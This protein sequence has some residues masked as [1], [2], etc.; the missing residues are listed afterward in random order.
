RGSAPAF[1]ARCGCATVATRCRRFGSS[2]YVATLRRAALMLC[3]SRIPLHL[4]PRLRRL[5][6]RAPHRGLLLPLQHPHRV[7]ARFAHQLVVVAQAVAAD[8]LAH[9][10][11]RFLLMA[12]VAEAALPRE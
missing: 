1:D 7:A 2:G 12:A 9:G 5:A 3:S 10:A 8:A 4:H 11:A 6:A